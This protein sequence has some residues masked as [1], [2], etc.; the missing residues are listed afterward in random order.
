MD[1]INQTRVTEFIIVGFPGLQDS[2]SKSVLFAVFLTLYLIIILGNLLLIGIFAADAGLHTPMY[3]TICNLAIIDITLPTFTVP[4]MLNVFRSASYAVPLPACFIQTYF[5]LAL[6][7]V[8]CFILLIMA[9]DRYLAIC[10]PLHYPIKMSPKFTFKLIIISWLGG[11]L[12]PLSPVIM[13][14]PKMME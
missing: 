10:H 13:G 8:E 9:Y 11:F 2:Q 1:N 3:M 6:G 12:C 7:C 4:T 5:F 14:S